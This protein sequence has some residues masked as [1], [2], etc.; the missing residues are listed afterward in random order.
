VSENHVPYHGDCIKSFAEQNLQPGGERFPR[1][2]QCPRPR[3]NYAGHD[4]GI[5]LTQPR[6]GQFEERPM[7]I[8]ELAEREP[9]HAI[10]SDIYRHANYAG[11]CYHE[12]WETIAKACQAAIEQDRAQRQDER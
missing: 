10:A 2:P 1:D 12:L 7:T 9:A 4:D 8:A 6:S 11:V 3:F 5:V